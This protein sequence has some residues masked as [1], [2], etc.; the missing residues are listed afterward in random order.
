MT[1]AVASE[2][3]I[4]WQYPGP[5]GERLETAFSSVQSDREYTQLISESERRAHLKQAV[6]KS[7]SPSCLDDNSVCRNDALAILRDLNLGGRVLATAKRTDMGYS[8]HLRY[9]SLEHKGARAFSA[10]A[11]SLEQAAREVL[12]AL[13]G[14]GTLSLGLTPDT[15]FFFLNDVPYGQGSGDHLITTGEYT[16]R[17]EAP[18][19]KSE[20][21]PLSIKTGQRVRVSVL[22]VEAG[23]R[24][25]LTTKPSGA[26]V[27][28][29]GEKWPDYGKLR[30][31]SAGKHA[32]RVELT[33]YNTF[34]QTL[35]LKPSTV[36]ELALSLVPSDPEWRRAIKRDVP[37]TRT[38]P[39]FIRGHLDVMSVR[40][41]TYDLGTS[42][43]KLERMADPLG[44][45][46]FGFAISLRKEQWL[47]DILRIKYSIA[48]G[49]SSGRMA[50]FGDVEVTD[51]SRLT[52]APAWVGLQ[53]PVWRIVPYAMGGILFTSETVNGRT[54]SSRFSGDQ[55]EFKLGAELG[56]RYVFSD[57]FFA[58]IHHTM[59]GFPGSGNN[60]SLGL[61]FGYAF[62][63][64]SM[65]KELLP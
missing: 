7:I 36:S 45:Q 55:V 54:G 12:N 21:M 14:Q 61:H 23:A 51:L 8:V 10:E 65:V 25:N 27:Y 57:S 44:G 46:S 24:I 26:T 29:D 59:E 5:Y 35:D 19:F 17:V 16:L 41:R 31:V 13:H 34:T 47:M 15:A 38:M 64:P 37:A 9:E 39:A 11:E 33:D 62:E 32:L 1:Q 20:S 28:L 50:N 2:S 49:E 43:S 58:G 60:V 52:I 3:P 22:L 63:L 30:T 56:V 18:G 48:S 42:L 6:K 40:D 53:H 4:Y